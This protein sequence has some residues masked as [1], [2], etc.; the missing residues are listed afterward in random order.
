MGLSVS[1]FLCPLL[2]RFWSVSPGRAET[3][4]IHPPRPWPSAGPVPH[5]VLIKWFFNCIDETGNGQEMGGYRTAP[6]TLF[7]GSSW[8]LKIVF[9]PPT[10]TPEC[11]RKMLSQEKGRLCVR[12]GRLCREHSAR[13]AP[14]SPGV[15]GDEIYK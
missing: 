6:F 4:L 9:K 10:M 14:A 7:S 3:E 15:E 11:E 12:N 13:V 5:H 1:S 2:S 8:F